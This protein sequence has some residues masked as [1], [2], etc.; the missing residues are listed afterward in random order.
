MACA[1]NGPDTEI[2]AYSDE[3]NDPA[4]G[5]QKV[6]HKQA[7]GSMHE[8]VTKGG[9]SAE[10]EGKCVTCDESM[11]VTACHFLKGL[12]DGGIVCA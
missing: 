10:S 11:G 4:S 1:V 8:E 6:D 7:P 3:T 5:E 12:L 9:P 2:Q